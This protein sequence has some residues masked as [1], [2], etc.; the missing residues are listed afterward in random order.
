[1]YNDK[2]DKIMIEQRAK[3]EKYADWQNERYPVTVSHKNSRRDIEFEERLKE[4]TNGK[5][6]NR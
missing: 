4:I 5:E 1:M 6:N 3:G 2:L